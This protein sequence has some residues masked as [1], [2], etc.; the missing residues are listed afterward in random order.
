MKAK[1]IISAALLFMYLAKAKGQTADV[2]NGCL[3]LTVSFEAPNNPE[4]YFWSFG[5]GNSS[6]LQN[7]QAVFSSVGDFLVELFVSEGGEKVGEINIEVYQK[8]SVSLSASTRFG[9]T[10]LEVQFTS[11]VTTDPRLGEAT[12]LWSFGD[13]GRS[14]EENPTYTYLNPGLMSV[15]LEVSTEISGC[16]TTELI[17]EYILVEGPIARFEI[18][19]MYSC[20]F[21]VTFE[22]DVEVAQNPENTYLWDFGDGQTSN[23]YNPGVVTYDEAG[24]FIIRHTVSAPEGCTSTFRDTVLV[25]PPIV[26]L[27]VPDIAC[28]GDSLIL[29][30]NIFAE[31]LEWEIPPGVR[32]IDEETITDEPYIAFDSSGTYT[33]GLRTFFDE[34]CVTEATF[35]VFV[36]EVVADFTIDPV[37]ACVD[38]VTV[39]LEAIGNSFPNYWWN[40]IQGGPSYSFEVKEPPRDSFYL[41]FENRIPIELLVESENGCTDIII[42]DF[43]HRIPD[44]V[45]I[46]DRIIGCAPMEVNFE[47]RSGSRETIVSWHYDLGN[48]DELNYSNSLQHQYTFT[49]PGTYCVRM[50]I[51]NSAG[52]RDTSIC[53]FITVLPQGGVELD[54]PQGS[55][56]LGDEFEIIMPVGAEIPIDGWQVDIQDLGF[57]HCWLDDRAVFQINAEPGEYELNYITA[58]GPCEGLV[59]PLDL[60]VVEGANSVI[61]YEFDCEDPLL[62]RF[63]NKGLGATRVLWNF[64]GL[65]NSTEAE[66]SFR[67]PASGDYV[68]F[69]EVENE[70]SPCRPHMSQKVIKVRD[71]KADFEF[72]D[73][74]CDKSPVL[75]DA[76]VTEGVDDGCHNSYTWLFPETRPR[77]TGVPQVR[78]FVP[79]GGSEVTLIARDING[80]RDTI[81]KTIEAFGITANFDQSLENFCAGGEIQFS[82]LS[83]SDTTIVNWEWDFGNDLPS[84][85]VTE[86]N[87]TFVYENVDSSFYIVTLD[88]ENAV[89]CRAQ[90]VKIIRTY[91][92]ASEIV[93]PLDGICTGATFDL[94][95]TDFTE[96]GSFLNYEWDMG[97]GDTVEGMNPSYAYNEPGTYEIILTYTEASSGCIG[98]DTIEFVVADL[99]QA[100][101]T[102]N[103]DGISPLCHP[104]IIEFFNETDSSDFVNF[105]W[106]F[107][108]GSES[109]LQN[110]V[111]S[112]GRGTFEVTLTNNT[113]G[114][115]S[116][117]TQSFTL[118]GPDGTL[119]ADQTE[120]C[121]GDPVTFSLSNTVDVN[122]WIWDFGDGNTNS[123]GENPITY[124]YEQF[125][126]DGEFE[127]CVVL[128]SEDTGCEHIECTPIRLAE[129]RADFNAVALGYCEGLA[130]FE[131]TS[132]GGAE[133]EWDF[134]DGNSSNEASTNHTYDDVGTYT[135][136]LSVS[137]SEGIC[138]SELSQ[139]LTLD[140]AGEFGLF[141]NVFSPNND[142]RNDFFNIVVDEEN[143]EFMEVVTFQV[144]NRWGEMVYDNES[145]LTGWDGRKDAIP[146][147]SEVYAYYIEVNVQD[148]NTIAM[149]GNVTLIR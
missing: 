40:G 7:P 31:F 67:F 71:L 93:D 70:D 19:E 60:L 117:A 104:Q 141:P 128:F 106:E 48:G 3:P 4:G 17:T 72:P 139:E 44:A 24:L 83:I 15:S 145:P 43:I 103:V 115:E 73:V 137:D 55:F 114:C 14:S 78:N 134:G 94:L 46:P 54:V 32:L 61:G 21:P 142:G 149:K 38:P 86:Q 91:D 125:P 5:N 23:E 42:K 80:C 33:F 95:A 51:E 39:N 123:D 74:V 49:E 34:D 62:V 135:V 96:Q 81:T 136:T 20:T 108:E 122:S 18:E 77:T 88:I 100:G 2:S 132:I 29:T 35:D 124:V 92:V 47:D 53:T 11:N 76:S 30:H 45:F 130:S 143:R 89:G 112:F 6:E 26:D 118:V 147:P 66:T 68:V 120:F 25:G 144:F 57:S 126:E 105:N 10:P 52:C 64:A 119:S 27:S 109:I 56:C 90:A 146:A 36:E 85:I 50:D 58:I 127:A 148:C 99:L 110:P 111:F 98:M 107:G 113:L 133:F 1:I 13:G 121:L 129:V 101:F 22:I 69:L 87:P 75:F 63:G 116:S 140:A 138:T 65:G 97:N 28:I 131:N 41:H 59:G 9:C 37:A 16:E 12:Y 84:S 102:T 8:P 82:D 79:S